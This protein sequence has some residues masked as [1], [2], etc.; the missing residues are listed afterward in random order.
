MRLFLIMLAALTLVALGCGGDKPAEEAPPVVEEP[1]APA[2][3]AK[4]HGKKPEKP[5]KPERPDKGKGT[6]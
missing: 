6:S 1:S 5:E 2:D 3:T 4:D